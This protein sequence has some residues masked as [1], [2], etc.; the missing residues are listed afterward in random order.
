MVPSWSSPQFR[1]VP[2]IGGHR[3]G[4][5]VL[6]SSVHSLTPDPL[7]PG[8]TSVLCCFHWMCSPMCARR[9][10]EKFALFGLLF[11]FCKVV[12]KVDCQGPFPPLDSS[13]P[14]L[15]NVFAGLHGGF[16]HPP[17]VPPPTRPQPRCPPLWC[18][19]CLKTSFPFPLVFFLA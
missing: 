3:F 9:F 18:L 12:G 8:T 4:M 6:L 14:P 13:P 10:L 16:P 11:E 7:M 17:G 1:L 15:C 2:T 5:T 19:D